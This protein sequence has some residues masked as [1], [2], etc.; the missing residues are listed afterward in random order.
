MSITTHAELLT[1]LAS[2]SGR[3]GLTAVDDDF[4]LMVEARLNMGVDGAFPTPPLRVRQMEERSTATITGEYL[5]LPDD[6][7]E[8]KSLRLTSVTPPRILTPVSTGS[9]D[10]VVHG[11]ETGASPDRY[12]IVG[13]EIRMNPIATS[14]TLEMIYYEKIPPLVSNDPNWLLTLAPNIY[15]FGV[16][17]EAAIFVKEPNDVALY[18]GLFS[19][20]VQ[21]LNDSGRDSSLES[22]LVARSDVR[23][24][25]RRYARA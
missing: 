23:P 20:Q 1:A 7:L 24:G 12:E 13:G 17:L 14:G 25:S 2:Y 4:V 3:S 19:A 16:L 15:L 10:Q 8:I 9:F 6:F 22:P 18:G 21:G 5:A 11:S